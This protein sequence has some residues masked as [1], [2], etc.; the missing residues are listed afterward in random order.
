M[1][2]ANAGF[3]PGAVDGGMIEFAVPRARKT[4]LLSVLAALGDV[5]AGFELREPTLEDVFL[6]HGAAARATEADATGPAPT[7]AEAAR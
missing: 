4:A 1:A 3:A 7:K 5:V 6:R 2:L